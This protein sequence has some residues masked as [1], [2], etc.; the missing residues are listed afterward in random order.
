MGKAHQQSKKLSQTN[1]KKTPV[2]AAS[3]KSSAAASGSK[4]TSADNFKASSNILLTFIIDIIIITPIHGIGYCLFAASKSNK[5]SRAS[6]KTSGRD[7]VKASSN[8]DYNL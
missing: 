1:V 3:T 2:E 7:F 8:V 5:S 6:K 4:K